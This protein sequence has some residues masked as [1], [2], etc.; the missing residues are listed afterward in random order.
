MTPLRQRMINDMTVRGL[1]NSTMA[2]SLRS[3][4][5]LSSQDTLLPVNRP[6]LVKCLDQPF[7][8]TRCHRYGMRL[9]AKGRLWQVAVLFHMRDAFRSGDIWFAHSRRYG[10]LKQAL[11]PIAAVRATARLAVPRDHS[12]VALGAP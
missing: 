6:P 4:T 3:V 9:I 11:V 7:V 10:D 8:L 5:L 1:A 2:S 12:R